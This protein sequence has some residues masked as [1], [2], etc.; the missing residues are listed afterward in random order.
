[1]FHAKGRSMDRVRYFKLCAVAL[2]LLVPI[3]LAAQYSSDI[4]ISANDAAD[5]LDFIDES[6]NQAPPACGCPP[7]PGGNYVAISD[8][9]APNTPTPGAPLCTGG[10][11][12]VVT[13]N[14]SLH[15]FDGTCEGPTC[16]KCR[17]W[18]GWVGSGGLEINHCA[19]DNS[20]C[21][22]ECVYEPVGGGSAFPIP[23]STIKKPCA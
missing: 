2:L 12:F 8:T 18:L 7:P 3:S 19:I 10:C 4:N 9:C 16:N 13:I 23:N 15:K 20:P 6:A 22:G 17:P 11:S 1:M 14:G 21:K 5:I